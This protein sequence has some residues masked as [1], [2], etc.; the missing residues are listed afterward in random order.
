MIGDG[1]PMP[2]SMRLCCRWALWLW[3]WATPTSMPWNGSMQMIIRW[4]TAGLERWWNSASWSLCRSMS[5]RTTISVSLQRRRWMKYRNRSPITW[6]RT[7]W[8]QTIWPRW[9]R[10]DNHSMW[11]RSYIVFSSFLLII[12]DVFSEWHEQHA[13]RNDSLSFKS[14]LNIPILASC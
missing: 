5:S 10:N 6:R 3:E 14:D 12:S 8:R 2:L 11:S 9:R 7:S 13:A 4:D 1:L